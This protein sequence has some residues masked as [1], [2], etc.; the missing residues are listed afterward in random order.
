[1]PEVLCFLSYIVRAFSYGWEKLW[2]FIL[3]AT[4]TKEFSA[5]CY[6]L[7][8]VW[9]NLASQLVLKGDPCWISWVVARKEVSGNSSTFRRCHVFFLF[10]GPFEVTPCLPA[11]PQEDDL[12]TYRQPVV[13]KYNKRKARFRNRAKTSIYPYKTRP[14]TQP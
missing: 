14:T 4:Y 10:G 6:N 9:Y 8:C 7:R 1:M 5:E 12:E 11:R 3:L 2:L 13:A